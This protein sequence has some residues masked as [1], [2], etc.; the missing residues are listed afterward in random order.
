MLLIFISL[1]LETLFIECIVHDFKTP[2][3]PSMSD[4]NQITVSFST[5]EDWIP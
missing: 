4:Y 1:K 3:L 2:I 5:G